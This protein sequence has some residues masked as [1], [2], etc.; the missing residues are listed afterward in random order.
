MEAWIVSLAGGNPVFSGGLALALLGA[1]AYWLKDVLPATAAFLS[2]YIVSMVT[3]DNRDEILFPTVVEYMH[4]RDVLRRINQFTVRA[5]KDSDAYQSFS[6]DLRQGVRP[7]AFLSPAEGFHIFWLDGRLMWMKREVSIG[8]TIF[9]KITLSTFGRD[10]AVLEAFI[11]AAI[12]ARVARELDKIA[13]YIPNPY[14]HGDWSRARLGNNRRL[15]SLVLKAGQ[16]E[17]ILSDLKQ[18]FGDKA[19]YDDLGIPWRRGY[20]L[21]GAPGTGKTSLVTALASEMR[22]NVCSLSLAASGIT[23]DKIGSLLA[24]VPPRSI[25]LIEDVDAFFRQ[26][27]QQSQQVRLSFSGFLNALDGV[28]AHEGSVVFMTTNH[29]ETLDAALV[30]SG[31]VDFR[32]ELGPCDHHQLAGMFR[33]FHDDPVLAAAFAAALPEGAL[34]PATVQERLLRART[35][36]EAFACFEL[37]VPVALAGKA[38]ADDD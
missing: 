5:V 37:P 21:Y 29:P 14:T 9:E 15:A 4:A 18:F 8:Q 27:E 17:R 30:R 36:A 2:R 13:I 23:D 31:R 16:T 3:V 1:V 20:L 22:L 32:M 34:A 25:I 33:K 11:H 26:R 7:R 38:A 10:K 24:S 12:E 28:A 19:R 6:D 35:P